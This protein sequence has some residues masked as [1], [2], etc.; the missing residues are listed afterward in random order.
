MRRLEG[1][2]VELEQQLVLLH[3]IAVL[4]MDLLDVPAHPGTQFDR[5]RRLEP[6]VVVVFVHEAPDDRM[7]HGHPGRLLGFLGAGRAAATRDGQRP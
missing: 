1:T 3:Q 6:A 5:L 7:G 4:E 2:R